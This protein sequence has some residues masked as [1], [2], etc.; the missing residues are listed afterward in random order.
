MNL[1]HVVFS[2]NRV[3]FLKKTFRA[4]KKLDFSG[5]NVHHLFIDDYPMGRDDNFIKEFVEYYGYDEIILHKENLGITK[6]WQELFDL[7]KE[8]NYDYIL[9]HEDDVELM[10]PLKVI[11]II[12][13]L[14]Q[15][16]TL[17]QIQLKRNNWYEHEVEE[18]G[19]KDEDVIFKDYRYEKATPYFWML[20]S[21]YPAWIAREPI[22]EETGF[23]PS[24][25]VI[26]N[27]LSSKYNIGAGL[28]KTSEGG[29]MVNHI[30]EYFHGQRVAENEPGWDG[31]KF[32]DPNLKYCSK[33]GAIVI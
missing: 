12:E 18:I 15:D 24:E 3:E 11:D 13:L 10:H 25:S 8:R 23:N 7:V 30:G 28:L 19:P 20:M 4:N 9:H 2:T 14:E 31:F 1:L 16:K 32:I 6:T 29:I 26:A 17:S 22:L 27:Y 5:L 21:L 33:T